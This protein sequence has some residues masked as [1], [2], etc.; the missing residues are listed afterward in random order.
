MK[1]YM[2]AL[3]S[4]IAFT[5]KAQQLNGFD[6]NNALIPAN[7]IL[8]GGPPKD[9]IPSIDNPV[10]KPSNQ[11]KEFDNKSEVLG[12]YYNGVAKAYPINIM[13]WHEI[14]NDNFK[15]KPVVVTYCP[16]CGSGIAFE[17]EVV[18]GK[19]TEF[20]VSGLLYNSDVLLYDRA[21]QSLW[22]QIMAKAVSGP[23]NGQD[24]VPISTQRMTFGSWKSLYPES[25]ILTTQT[26]F[27][28]NYHNSAYGNYDQEDR[29]YFPV[30]HNDNTF[31]KKEW[32]IG[33]EVNGAFKAYSVKQLSKVNG[34]SL[35]DELAGTALSL[36]WDQ[37]GENVSIQ[38]ADGKEI[39]GIQMF[40]FAWVAFH[41]DTE[42]Y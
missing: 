36:T 3:I 35:E 11:Y 21:T 12:V 29:T 13:D 16:L 2:L 40:W 34:R 39:I 38:T 14:V 19:S 32:V 28:R 20:G 9:G 26:G 37:K 24:L 1:F 33:I 18:K 22:S 23:L 31:H 7:D 4:L 27:T 25:E 15:G 17:A 10:F 6:L 8:R 5:S 41:P 42:V 30:S